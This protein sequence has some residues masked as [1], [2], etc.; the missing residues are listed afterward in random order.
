MNDLSVKSF[1]ASQKFGTLLSE[2][3]FYM[4]RQTA[5]EQYMVATGLESLPTQDQDC[6]KAGL[7]RPHMSQ[8]GVRKRQSRH[9]FPF[10]CMPLLHVH[11]VCLSSMSFHVLSPKDSF[12]SGLLPGNVSMWDGRLD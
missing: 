5:R 12:I 7:L 6:R 10:F 3:K 1:M 4:S 8:K 11:S 2:D 9:L